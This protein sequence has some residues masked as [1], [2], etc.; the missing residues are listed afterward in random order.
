MKYWTSS[1]CDGIILA[2]VV[3]LSATIQNTFANDNFSTNTKLKDYQGLIKQLSKCEVLFFPDLINFCQ[4][5]YIF[6]WNALVCRNIRTVGLIRIFSNYN[7]T[8]N[9]MRKIFICVL[10]MGLLRIEL[11]KADVLI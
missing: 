7:Q 1:Q 2:I 10:L 6:I 9:K 11:F 8:D 4:C 5:E 3:L